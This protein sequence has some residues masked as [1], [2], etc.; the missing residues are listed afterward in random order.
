MWREIRTQDNRGRLPGRPD[1][2]SVA[3]WIIRVQPRMESKGEERRGDERR[4]A[5]GRFTGNYGSM[6]RKGTQTGDFLY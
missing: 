4:L 3:V 5:P 1:A 6:S 2:E